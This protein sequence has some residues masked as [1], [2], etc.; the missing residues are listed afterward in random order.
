M[1]KHGWEEN[2]IKP[3]ENE[4]SGEEHRVIAFGNS[5]KTIETVGETKVCGPGQKK[6][7]FVCIAQTLGDLS[8]VHVI[9]FLRVL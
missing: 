5:V 4:C 3:M 1:A 8:T 2:L 7:A 9:C 6:H